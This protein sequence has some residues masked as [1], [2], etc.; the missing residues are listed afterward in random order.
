MDETVIVVGNG[1]VGQ[2]FCALLRESRGGERFRL[3]A[4]G[5]EPRPAYD[6][7]HLTE[8]FSGKSAADLEIVPRSWYR[9]QSIDLHVGAE[10]ACIDRAGKTVRCRDGRDFSYDH[11]VLATGSAPFVPPLPG[12]ERQ[13]VF[14]YRTIE[15]LD[16]IR[17]RAR[18][19]HSAAVIGGGLLGLEAAK[20]LYDLGLTAHVVEAAPWLMPR[21]L[22]RDGAEM[23][24]D[25]IRA[26]GVHVHTGVRTTEIAEGENGALRFV[27]DGGG[28]LEVE[29]IIVSAG[30]RPRQELAA[31]CGLALGPRGGVA[32]DA[33]MRT[34]DPSILAVGECASHD[35]TVYGL[36]APGFEMADVAAAQIA[37]FD[38]RFRAGDMSTTLKLLG[39]EVASIGESTAPPTADHT[40]VAVRDEVAGVYKKLII[41]RDTRTLLGAVLVGDASDYA[42]LLRLFRRAEPLAERPLALIVDGHVAH[43]GDAADLAGDSVLCTCNNVTVDDVVG[44]VAGGATTM[45]AVQACTRA[46]TGCGGCAPQIKQVLEMELRRAGVTVQRRICEHFALRRQELFDLIRVRGHRTYAEVLAGHGSGEGGCE[47]CKPVVASILASI[48]AEPASEQPFI[49]DTNDRFLANIQRGGSYSVIPRIP[50][51]EITAEKL[52]AIGQVARRYDLYLK[53]TGGQRIDMFGARLD[54]LPSIWAELIA[55][56]F[57]SGHAYAKA[58]RTVKSCVGSTW[59]R[60][61][62]LDSV[63]FA[64]RVEER[65]KGLRAPHKLKS[66]VSGCIRECA[67]ARSKDFGIIATSEGWNLYVCGNGGSKPRHGVLLA[68]GLDDDTCLRYIDRFLM[69]YVRTADPLTRTARWFEELDGGIDYLRAVIIEDV[70]GIGA[71]LDAEM[72]ATVDDYRCEWAAV[73]N[74]PE[75]R[76]QFQAF[77]NAPDSDPSIEFTGERGQKRPASGGGL[78]A[79]SAVET[80]V[81]ATAAASL[82]ETSHV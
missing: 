3:I 74:D 76:R 79:L 53:I 28:S 41:R 63:A 50:G 2:R 18:S 23:L 37:G 20:A 68:G 8:Y 30:I 40:H 51:G 13:G 46:A 67:E 39:V 34:S 4:L 25:K 22:D 65:Y 61:G 52:I 58:M 70:L 47:V 78:L 38:K 6:R 73:V 27:F 44:A 81:P 64:I 33:A 26:L 75:K 19:C 43:T 15:D 36:V 66:A 80:S 14:I 21:Q 32:V 7:V 62:V 69:F 54:Q 29:M 49:Q 31:A 12:I 16:A 77:I 57:E 24:A 71:Q 60:F 48:H 11:L 35:G 56:G 82:E 10:V 42:N 55:A 1:M 17:E 45:P 9:E 59:C 72:Q 5:E